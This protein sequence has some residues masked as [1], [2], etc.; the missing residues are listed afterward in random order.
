MIEIGSQKQLFL[1]DYLIESMTGVQRTLNPATK[2]RNNPVIRPDRPWEGNNL[3]YGCVFY[4]EEQGLFR[5]WYTASTVTPSKTVRLV[6]QPD[7]GLT[8]TPLEQEKP[9]S[10]EPIVCYATSTDGYS[11]EKPS[12]GLVKFNGSWENNILIVE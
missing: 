1:D 8:A 10:T 5:L 11:W 2:A 12:L 7:A 3:H 6:T 4:D 9:N